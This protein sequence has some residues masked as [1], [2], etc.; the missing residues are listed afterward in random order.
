MPTCSLH[1]EQAGKALGQK[2]PTFLG[3]FEN[4]FYRRV[5][6]CQ[7][8]LVHSAILAL[9]QIIPMIKHTELFCYA[10]GLRAASFSTAGH[11]RHDEVFERD[12]P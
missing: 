5:T 9:L 8:H 4:V 10:E 11:H 2:C 3:S 7:E 12:H 1:N 6:K